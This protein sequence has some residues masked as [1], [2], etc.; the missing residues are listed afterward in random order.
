[1]KVTVAAAQYPITWHHHFKEWEEHTERWVREAACRGARLLLFPE[2]GAMELVSI[3][4]PE[5]QADIHLQVRAMARLEDDFRTVF[6]GLTDQYN[7][8]I[9]APSFPVQSGNQT[10]NR[11][12]VFAPKGRWGYQDKYF[13]TRFEQEDWDVRRAPLRY[14]LF[15][16]DF[17][18]FGIQ[19]CYDLEFPVGAR[20]LCRHGATLILGP[21][22]TET[23]RGSTRV[24]VSGRAR[25]LEQQCYCVVSQTVGDAPWSQTTDVNYGYAGIYTPPD[26]GLPEEGILA[27][28]AHQEPGWLVQMLDFDLIEAVRKDGQVLNFRDQGDTETMGEVVRVRL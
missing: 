28:M 24:H 16:T 22:C 25:A 17:G 18:S 6:A 2:Y 5:E 15:D 27:T 14:S 7:V 12:F 1:M 9:A 23:I 13:M 4:T 21:S 19:I 26:R 10:F 11:C 3:L 8:I 20:A